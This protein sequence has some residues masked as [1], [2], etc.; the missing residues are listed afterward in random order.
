MANR[1]WKPFAYTC[2][3]LAKEL[4]ASLSLA[5]D[6]G[7]FLGARWIGRLAGAGIK[8]CAM[9]AVLALSSASAGA[10]QA[11]QIPKQP[12]GK[13]AAEQAQ[14]NAA[15]E[16][17]QAAATRQPTA[18]E[19]ESWRKT[20]LHTPRPKEGCFTATY[21]ETEWREVPCKTPP[22]K[23]YPPKRSGMAEQVGGVI[24]GVG[25]PDFSP[26]VT[27]HI[28]EAEGSFDTVTGVTSECAVPCP[29]PTYACP[30]S[31]TCTG[32]TSPNTYSLQLNSKPFTTS[33]C[34]GSPDPAGCQGW[35]QFVYSS[36]GGGFI[37]YWL[38]NYGP[39]GT[40]CPMPR[41]AS[42]AILGVESDGWCPFSFSGDTEVYC[43]VNAVNSAPA[44]SEPATSLGEMKLT[45]D[46][47]T[48][49]PPANDSVTVTVPVGTPPIPKPFTA[50]GNNYFPDL[51]SQWQ[52]VEFNVFG[53]GG[54]DQAVFNSG[55][56]VA[57][58]TSVASGTSSGPGCDLQSFTGESNNL[59]LN[60]TAP[61]AVPGVLPALLFSEVNPAPSG[62][63]AT[64]ADATS[65][66]DTH[67]TTFDGLYY[68]FQ[69]SGDFVLAQDG[70]DFVVQTRQESGAPIW[71]DMAVNKA[72]ATQ[73]GKTRVAI[74]VEPTRL[75]IDGAANN[76]AD[77]K[78][79]LLP[80]GVQVSRQVTTQGDEYVIL[81][82]SGD[83]VTALLQNAVQP[84]EWWINVTVGL[85]HAPQT[86]VRGLLGNPQG[87]AQELATSNGVVLNAPV[88]FTDLYHTYADSWRV[89]P[90]ESLFTDPTTIT[91]GIPTE[92]FFASDLD[93]KVAATALTACK[94]AGITVQALL[95]SCT[96]DTAVLND[97]AAVKVFIHA[98]PPRN[99]I[100][101]VLRVAPL[102]K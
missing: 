88:S 54:G 43:V 20:I 33:A 56:T 97:K 13:P 22:H 53:D 101:P 65:V 86:E 41:G 40:L 73:M 64:C 80:T 51:G 55:A 15:T 95:D 89:Q 45:G 31:P 75:V 12:Q 61:A 26:V 14:T 82:D 1:T 29:P 37:Q 81:S 2:A 4:N 60:N 9:L 100:K 102:A 66:G 52:E 24:G 74:Y 48:V 35:E 8:S 23:L 92:P 11:A 83:H 10:G 94:A 85:G 42:C 72:V 57:V 18:V 84:P 50:S 69:A 58:R 87:N 44:P 96:L 98:L 59:T 5:Q 3:L 28:T 91:P 62:A 93:P 17:A 78:T 30:T 16:Q 71:P 68:D 21:P 25:G 49:S 7:K 19:L 79:I 39:G 77:G 99:V 34:S 32:S 67:L 76:L 63:P 47:G 38:E 6:R 70:S 27:G 46:A 36:S 90:N